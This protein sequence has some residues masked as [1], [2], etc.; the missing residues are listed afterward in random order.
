MST[1]TPTTNYVATLQSTAAGYAKF[2]GT[3]P[4]A[5]IYIPGSDYMYEESFYTVFTSTTVGSS[6]DTTPIYYGSHINVNIYTGYYAFI[7]INTEGGSGVSV[8]YAGN[9]TFRPGTTVPSGHTGATGYPYI[10]IIELKV[11]TP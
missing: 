2:V 8:Y 10:A 5:T 6:T 1:P 3:Q 4:L 9:Y 11:F 7:G